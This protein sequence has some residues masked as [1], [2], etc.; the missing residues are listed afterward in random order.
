MYNEARDEGDQGSL[1]RATRRIRKV[2]DEELRR[3]FVLTESVIEVMREDRRQENTALPKFVNESLHEHQLQYRRLEQ[4]KDDNEDGPAFTPSPE[5]DRHPAAAA[6]RFYVHEASEEHFDS[7]MVHDDRELQARL[8]AT[9]E[10]IAGT[11]VDVRDEGAG[12]RTVPVWVVESK[13]D[14]PLRLREDSEVCV[15][16]LPTRKLRIRD[17]EKTPG[18]GYRFELVVTA[19]IKGPRE[20]DGSVLTAT[21]PRLKGRKVVLVKPSMDQI[22]RRKSML[23]WKRDVPGAWLTHAVPKVPEARLPRGVAEDLREIGA[24][25]A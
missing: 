23:I 25:D 17:I 7:L 8:V 11:I 10:A 5:T 12:R 21:S 18:Q 20:N 6:S 3:R 2:L 9:G 22:A 15:V 24:K 19:L 14:L 4:N 16:G 1:D 13:G